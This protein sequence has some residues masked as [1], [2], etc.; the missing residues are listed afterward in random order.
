VTPRKYTLSGLP[1]II[2]MVIPWVVGV[3]TI[4]RAIFS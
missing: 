4:I 1:F 3:V 2:L